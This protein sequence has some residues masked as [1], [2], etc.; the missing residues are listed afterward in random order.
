[1]EL[2]K[3]FLC[4]NPFLKHAIPQLGISDGIVQCL[5]PHTLSLAMCDSTLG[6]LPDGLVTVC[7]GPACTNIFLTKVN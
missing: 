3:H 1:M 2:H 4:H 7:S 5:L 6:G